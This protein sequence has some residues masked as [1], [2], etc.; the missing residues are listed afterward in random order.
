[1]WG[2]QVSREKLALK[3]YAV[4][5]FLIPWAMWGLQVSREKL[6][7]KTYARAWHGYRRT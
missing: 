5:F 7:L 3:T 2:L 4:S 1:M 6:A